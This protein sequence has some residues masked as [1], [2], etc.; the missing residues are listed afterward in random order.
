MN[1]KKTA[2]N[3]FV[4]VAKLAAGGDP[5]LLRAIASALWCAAQEAQRANE[6]AATPQPTGESTAGEGD[7]RQGPSLDEVSLALRLAERMDAPHRLIAK[8]ATGPIDIARPVLQKSPV[9]SQD[10]LAD[11]VIRCSADHVMTVAGRWDIGPQLAD[12]LVAHGNDD[13]LYAVLANDS[14]RLSAKTLAGLAK[15]SAQSVR[16]QNALLAR[17]DLPVDLIAELLDTVWGRP[18]D[19]LLRKLIRVDPVDTA[20]RIRIPKSTRQ[21]RRFI[22]AVNLAERLARRRGVDESVLAEL[23]A[24]KNHLALLISCS[25]LFGIDLDTTLGVLMDKKGLSFATFCRAKNLNVETFSQ[26][27]VV[28]NMSA[29]QDSAAILSLLQLYRRL[30]VQ[31]AIRA[32]ALWRQDY[33]MATNAV[34]TLQSA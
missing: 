27:I 34:E 20:Q 32:I 18:R 33:E 1:S 30:P 19:A 12:A 11:I 29:S 13:V 9:L 23:A 4:R 2:L 26:I 17:R 15:R 28:P 5:D 6:P 3:E 22:D 8:M 21:S 16:L 14:A 24:Q 10:E 25:K 31:D 7:A